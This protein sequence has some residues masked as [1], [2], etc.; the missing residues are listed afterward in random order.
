MDGEK[1]IR[2]RNI[3]VNLKTGNKILRTPEREIFAR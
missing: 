3:I 2:E 1:I